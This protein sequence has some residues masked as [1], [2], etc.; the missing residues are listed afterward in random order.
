ML[1]L[2]IPFFY[3][4]ILLI[5]SSC[6]TTQTSDRK[7]QE[8]NSFIIV[9][10]LQDDNFSTLASS[11]LNDSTKGGIIA[12]FNN[13]ETLTPGREVIIPLKPFKPGGLSSKGYQTVPVLSYHRISKTRTSSM[14]L[15]EK[16][17]YE[18]MK[19]LKDEGYRVITLDQL[20]D[21]VDFKGDIPDKSVVITF[22]DGWKSMLTRAYPILRDFGFPATL[23]VYT[24]FVGTKS[25]LSWDDIKTLSKNGID[26]QCHSKTHRYLSRPKKGEIFRD[27]FDDI[28]KELKEP[29]DLLRKKIN[30]RCEYM[31]YPYGET[32]DLV[33][34][35]LQKLGYKGAFTVKRGGNPFF[36]GRYEINRSMI[37]GN[38]EMKAFKRSLQVF[39]KEKLQ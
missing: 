23:F 36:T 31:A 24:D 2:K 28:G 12:D 11:Y 4:L 34:T 33:V 1:K 7:E 18:Q 6:V 35:T 5:L 26:I 30:R 22:D 20:M 37:Y 15:P 21:F 27:Y 38:F 9:K 10:P 14:E 29:R 8:F 16:K 32:N 39:K 13:I 3:I 25:G 17:F 19:Y